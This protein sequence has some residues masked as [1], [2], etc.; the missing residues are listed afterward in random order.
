M[1]YQALLAQLH[2]EGGLGLA[3]NGSAEGALLHHF[4]AAYG[5]AQAADPDSAAAAALQ[6][7]AHGSPASA[8]RAGSFQLSFAQEVQRL[9]LFI[10]SSLEQLW[11]ALLD[12]CAQ[13]R[14][15]SEELL[16]A[17]RDCMMGAGRMQGRCR[18]GAL[19]GGTSKE[20]WPKQA[21]LPLSTD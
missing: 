1:R 8:G 13:L 18:M 10:K 11:L 5:S 3:P 12:A 4:L 19:L 14:T 17:S 21:A 15:L 7:L 2:A 6:A 20:Q 9:R 16:Q